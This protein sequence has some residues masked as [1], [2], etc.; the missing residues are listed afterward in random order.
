M[1]LTLITSAA[2]IGLFFGILIFV[3]IGRR[4]GISRQAREPDAASA[5]PMLLVPALNAMIDITTTRLVATRN[6]LALALV[7][8]VV[9][10]LEFPRLGLIRID[11]ADQLF[12]ELRSGMR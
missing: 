11:A 5:A 1:N 7:S 10:D 2:T 12:I 3:E 4:I 9:I 6:H 8:Y